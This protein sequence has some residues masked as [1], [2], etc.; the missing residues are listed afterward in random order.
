MSKR[1]EVDVDHLLLVWDTEKN[2]RLEIEDVVGVLNEQQ[3]IIFKLQDLCGE[4]DGENAK[5]R[6]KNKRLQAENEELRFALRA[7]QA[8]AK[9][10]GIK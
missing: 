8:L 10:Q 4:S 5:L 9:I 6:I 1:F 2:K 3:D 7:E